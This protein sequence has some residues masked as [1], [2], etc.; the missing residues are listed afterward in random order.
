MYTKLSGNLSFYY[1][2]ESIKKQ[3]FSNSSF[4]QLSIKFISMTWIS[5]LKY[6]HIWNVCIFSSFQA[7]MFHIVISHL[8][9]LLLH[10]C[11]LSWIISNFTPYLNLLIIVQIENTNKI[12]TARFCARVWYIY[13]SLTLSCCLLPPCG[14]GT[15]HPSPWC[16]LRRGWAGSRRSRLELWLRD[17]NGELRRDDCFRGQ[18]W[19]CLWD[20]LSMTVHADL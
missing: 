18:S 5:L 9:F 7:F 16:C 2:L 3:C 19:L 12:F 8:Y 15:L 11:Q 17:L 6:F 13:S 1:I 14:S 20:F 4:I 10:S